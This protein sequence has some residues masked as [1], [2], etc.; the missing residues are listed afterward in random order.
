[1]TLAEFI[2][3]VCKEVI[4]EYSLPEKNANKKNSKERKL[5]TEACLHDLI[6][7]NMVHTLKDS[8]LLTPSAKDLLYKHQ[9]SSK[10]KKG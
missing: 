10:Q 3:D 9:K 6:S 7:R 2:T 8:D 4:A 1:M 5:I